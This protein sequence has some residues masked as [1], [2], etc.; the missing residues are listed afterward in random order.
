MHPQ[1]TVPCA[2]SLYFDNLERMYKQFDVPAILQA[3]LLIPYLNRRTQMI[4]TAGDLEKYGKLKEFIVA[5]H[6]LSRKDYRQRFSQAMRDPKE[7]NVAYVSRLSTLLNYWLR[8]KKVTT[9]DGIRDLHILEKLHDTLHLVVLRHV[10]T[11][12]ADK[13]VTAMHA[14]EIADN[15]EGNLPVDSKL[16]YRIE[17][18]EPECAQS[19]KSRKIENRKYVKNVSDKTAYKNSPTD[20]REKDN[21]YPKDDT[22]KEMMKRDFSK[23]PHYGK[24]GVCWSCGESK[25]T[26]NAC[27]HPFHKKTVAVNL[28]S[29]EPSQRNG[30]PCQ[31]PV[32]CRIDAVG[33]DDNFPMPINV[34]QLDKCDEVCH[35]NSDSDMS[36]EL[37]VNTC[38]SS[39]N[40]EVIRPAELIDAYHSIENA[41]LYSPCTV[42]TFD[43]L[44]YTFLCVHR[45]TDADTSLTDHDRVISRI[46]DLSEKPN[47]P[48]EMKSLSYVPVQV[49]GHS[50]IYSC[51]SDSGSM[52]PIIK[53]LVGKSV[54]DLGPIKLRTAFGHTVDAHLVS[55]DVKL[56]QS[57][58]SHKSPFLPL[59]FAVVKELTEDV[60]LPESTVKELC[61]YASM[62][63]VKVE[64]VET[65][66]QLKNQ[67]NDDETPNCNLTDDDSVI[68]NDE[69]NDYNNDN[70]DDQDLESL[71]FVVTDQ[72]KLDELISE[73]QNDIT[74]KDYIHQAQVSKG[75]YYFKSGALFHRKKIANQ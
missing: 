38:D 5:Q 15:F 71:P 32:V 17:H 70:V 37:M 42:D 31:K 21:L 60:I 45:C 66:S 58:E 68:I 69:H 51:L 23:L 52:I 73:Q 72:S 48:S 61:E 12:E 56:Y 74:L 57:S 28:C 62:E 9:F 27:K 44:F 49:K 3:I 54:D 30:D 18:Y 33:R 34:N 11:I 19:N 4:I 47:L 10:V 40:T 1:P 24:K 41:D 39:H 6:K 53:Q 35:I 13:N 36:E 43:D 59:T 63:E 7:T 64:T 75:N 26:N 46:S 16:R 29:A 67:T 55:L 65:D 50:Q 25:N 20:K 22:K 8:S 14:A 2:L